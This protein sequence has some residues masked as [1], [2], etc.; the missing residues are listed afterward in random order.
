[1]VQNDSKKASKQRESPHSVP[2]PCIHQNSL[3]VVAWS[4]FLGT[5]QAAHARSRDFQLSPGQRCRKK[6]EL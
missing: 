4:A 6:D 1:L 5:E 3:F 2:R